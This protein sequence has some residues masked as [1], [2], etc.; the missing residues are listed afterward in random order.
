MP[1]MQVSVGLVPLQPPNS[2]AATH[3]IRKNNLAAMG[4]IVAQTAHS[5]KKTR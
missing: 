4:T 3:E 1:G 5:H 2:A